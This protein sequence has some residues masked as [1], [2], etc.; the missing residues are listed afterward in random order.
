MRLRG[1]RIAIG[2]GLFAVALAILAPAA[3]V[4][5]VLAARTHDAWRIAETHGLWWNG[6]G[7][8]AATEGQARVPFAWRVTL[9][10]LMRGTLVT[11]LATPDG[12]PFAIVETARSR[13][14]VRDL[15]ARIPAALAAVFASRV[16]PALRTLTAGG[17]LELRSPHFEWSD[18]RVMG[19]VDAQWQD[20]R[21]AVPGV[22]LDLGTITLAL[23]PRA[24]GPV[25][26]GTLV[27]RGGDLA[28]SG[29]AVVN[30]S[31]ISASLALAPRVTAPD[32]VRGVLALL[33]SPDASGTV[34]VAWQSPR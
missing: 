27:N 5:A 28:L 8:L 26:D 32:L 18:G 13:V 22:S 10:D 11:T 15:D 25:L 9:T 1:A 2:F 33:G 29:N 14:V 16:A 34:H 6:R 3:I 30:G 17:T 21:I 24:G 7:V 19:T 20:A 31:T 12:A 4:D 23:R